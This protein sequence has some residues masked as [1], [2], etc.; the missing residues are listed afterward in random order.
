MLDEYA[1][2]VNVKGA[3]LKNAISDSA[4]D[5]VSLPID[6][7][8]SFPGE[9]RAKMRTHFAIGYYNVRTSDE[10]IARADRIRKSFNSPF[11]PFVLSTTSIGQEGLDFH[12]Y[13]RK[14]MQGNGQS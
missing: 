9:G 2:V 6:T 5:T 13:C 12:C 7:Q 11:R 8:E 10:T 3:D 4:V 14:V 1:H